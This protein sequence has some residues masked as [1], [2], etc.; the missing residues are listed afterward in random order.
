MEHIRMY[1][2]GALET[3]GYLVITGADLYIAVDAPEGFTDW[4]LSHR[5]NARITD[6]LITHQHFDHIQDAA[7]MKRQF[8]CTVHAHS[9]F[10]ESL[11]LSRLW[12]GLQL[13]PFE[14]DDVIGEARH[15][16]SWG[17]KA[18]HIHY[19]PGHAPDSL[20]YH[21]A[22]ESI[23]FSGD[24]LFAGSIGRSDFPGGDRNALLGGLRARILNQPANTNVY[25]GHGPYTTIKNEILS[26]PFIH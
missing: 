8:G 26:N 14:V 6:L 13:E 1:T 12:S 19:V 10:T 11:T 18:W 20:V 3:N 17:G 25:P 5:P 22:D 23:L 24:V 16:D 15:T 4:I 7:R 9:P 21:M 2:G